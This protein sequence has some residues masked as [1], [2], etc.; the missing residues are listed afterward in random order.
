MEL[1]YEK[2][3]SVKRTAVYKVAL[4]GDKST[5]DTQF[6]TICYEVFKTIDCHAYGY[7]IKNKEKELSDLRYMNLIIILITNSRLKMSEGINTVLDF[8]KKNYIRYI[9]I[10]LQKKY[11]KAQYESIFGKTQFIKTHD[12]NYS[13]QLKRF[14]D[15][16]F[17]QRSEFNRIER[18]FEYNV[19]LSY[20]KK[21]KIL[22]KKFINEIHRVPELARRVGIWYDDYLTVGES[23]DDNIKKEIEKC[24]FVVMAVTPRILEE[25]NYVLKTEYPDACKFGK[26][27]IPVVLEN[28][29]LKRL[30]TTYVNLP[31][32]YV[33]KNEFFEE[34]KK[35][36]N[37]IQNDTPKDADYY[38]YKGM[39][40]FYGIRCRQDSD[41]CLNFLRRAALDNHMKAINQLRYMYQNGEGI[42]RDYPV[43]MKYAERLIQYGLNNKDK[44][45]YNDFSHWCKNMR[46]MIDDS[47]TDQT[48]RAFFSLS[49][50]SKSYDLASVKDFLE[51]ADYG[52]EA[53]KRF[54]RI[55]DYETAE[56]MIKAAIDFLRMAYSLRKDSIAEYAGLYWKI[57]KVITAL[58][59]KNIDISEIDKKLEKLRTLGFFDE[60]KNSK[61]L[62]YQ[63]VA[64]ID[65]DDYPKVMETLS[66]ML[67][68][69]E[70][71]TADDFLSYQAIS[72]E[73][74]KFALANNDYNLAEGYSLM[75]KTVYYK[76]KP[77]KLSLDDQ[78]AFYKREADA[79]TV[80]AEVKEKA[81]LYKEAEESLREALSA[82]EL[83]IKSGK[84]K[85]ACK[86]IIETHIYLAEYSGYFERT[87]QKNWHIKKAQE[88]AEIEWK[89]FNDN[90]GVLTIK[91][92]LK[93][94]W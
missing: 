21:D 64:S 82:R 50:L 22:I 61:D 51:A 54:Y 20:R 80:Y 66:I 78:Y 94:N 91:E 93:N 41:L 81:K 10:V 26:R 3:N 86:D 14:L 55:E 40:F 25:N 5:M 47:A 1:I 88:Y 65:T 73:I 2:Q 46:I 84:N 44:A 59:N 13:E 6:D 12:P 92:Y 70:P 30:E 34:L 74:A 28:T 68:A 69:I 35:I 33:N 53:S 87:A 24:D 60:M 76:V 38:Y 4:V 48:K 72:L 42:S 11:E 39:A 49:M 27:I 43:A 57:E 23:Y 77:E 18:A 45:F 31:K 89:Q 62:F 17:V 58:E 7:A 15:D 19:F 75:A 37:K 29:D 9:P 63:M 8:A 56:E 85:Q 83:E 16:I 32:V 90:E 36:A 52:I 79:C 71:K 67:E